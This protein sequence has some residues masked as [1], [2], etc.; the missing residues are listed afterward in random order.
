MNYVNNWQRAVVLAAGAT[1]LALDLPN[2]DYRLTLTDSATNPTRWEIIDATVDGGTADIARGMEGTADQTWPSGSVIY[3]SLTAGALAGLRGVVSVTVDGSKHLIVT[4]SDG[5]TVDAGFV[6]GPAGADG[7]DGDDGVGFSGATVNG[8]GHLILTF[9]TG[10]TVDAGSVLGPAG[11]GIS[12]G[13]VDGSGHLVFTFTDGSTQDVGDV[14][15]GVDGEDGADGVDGRGVAS[16]V[17]NSSGDLVFTF[18]DSTTQNAG[19][20]KGDPGPA[21]A[22]DVAGPS[23]SVDGEVA[24]FSGTTGK[25]LKRGVLAD[26]V[27]AVAA[28]GIS[29]ATSTA[30]LATDTIL[31]ALGKLQAQISKYRPQTFGAACS[32]LTTSITTGTFKGYID[33]PYDLTVTDVYCTLATAQISG[34]LVTVDV[35]A[36]G[37]SIL[38][39]KLTIDNTEVSSK[40]AVTPPTITTTA[41]AAGT[42]ISFDI[43]QVGASSVAKGLICYVVG[44]PA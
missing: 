32:D 38:G 42:R 35:N 33:L 31:A 30:V 13:V 27:R 44:Y 39:D 37:V 26:L 9:T 20:V 34:S 41:L 12:S 10:G 17:V 23:A 36:N 1:S 18:T 25:L 8:S 29:F 19:H 28:T 40:T 24:L 15:N 4:Y 22:G 16:V 7:L 2:G 11:R 5:A 14:A 6:G 21:G 3:C 43:D